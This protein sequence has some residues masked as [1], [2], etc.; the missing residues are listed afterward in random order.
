MARVLVLDDDKLFG[1]LMRRGLEQRGHDVTLAETAAAARELLASN[2]FDALVCDIIL[3]DDSGLHVL[4]DV[5]EA[6][7]ALA[8][9][10]ISGGKAA[11]GKSVPLDVLNL[12]QTI[13][14]D[15]VVKKPIEL[16]S[17]VT[18]VEGALARKSASAKA[19]KSS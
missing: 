11:S 2:S 8:A 5:R 6:Y 14:V 16:T 9:V 17:F 3:P 19:V 13:G 18:T 7:P 15:A 4:R 1:A 12:A 10:A